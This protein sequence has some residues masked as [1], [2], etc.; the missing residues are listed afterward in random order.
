MFLYA[1][2]NLSRSCNYQIL[3]IYYRSFNCSVFDS[4][5]TF[6]FPFL[7]YMMCSSYSHPISGEV[8]YCCFKISLLIL[9]KR[10]A[11]KAIS[12]RSKT[13]QF[14]IRFFVS[15]KMYLFFNTLFNFWKVSFFFNPH[16]PSALLHVNS[17]F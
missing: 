13:L 7:A 12:D 9:E 3:V 2:L 1:P 17:T 5:N 16:V 11:L 15:Q 14:S 4:P 8:H 6:P 10:S